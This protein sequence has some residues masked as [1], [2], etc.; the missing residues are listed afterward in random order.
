MGEKFGKSYWQ[1]I[2]MEI[3]KLKVVEKLGL[4]TVM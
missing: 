4:F 2:F 1:M 3:I